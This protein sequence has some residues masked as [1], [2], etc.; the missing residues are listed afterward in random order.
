M[1]YWFIQRTLILVSVQRV[2]KPKSTTVHF[3]IKFQTTSTNVFG[4]N[5][6]RFFTRDVGE[7]LVDG[8]LDGAGLVAVER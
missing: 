5:R 6:F 7:V 8:D 3:V 2:Y 1:R 4:G